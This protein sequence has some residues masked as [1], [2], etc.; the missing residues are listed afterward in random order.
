M[1]DINQES[2]FYVDN[3]VNPVNMVQ[4]KRDDQFINSV[5]GSLVKYETF[6]S[7]FQSKK[8]EDRSEKD[9]KLIADFLKTE[10]YF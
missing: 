4:L 6:L 3:Y 7:M 8:G 10:K 9:C 1:A 2:Q 5:V